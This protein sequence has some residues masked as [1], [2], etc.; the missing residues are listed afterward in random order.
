MME[1]QNLGVVVIPNYASLSL[2]I[3]NVEGFT[4][5]A[6]ITIHNA[7]EARGDFMA[8]PEPSPEPKRKRA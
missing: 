7:L 2:G 5:A 8:K 1:T 6:R 3:K 4:N